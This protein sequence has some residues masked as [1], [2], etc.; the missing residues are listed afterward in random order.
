MPEKET[1]QRARRDKA[2][3]KKPTVQAGEFVREEMHHLREGKHDAASPKQAI[4]IGLA[5]AR[6]AGVDLPPPKAG[7]AKRKTRQSAQSAYA[8]GQ[9]EGPLS[10]GRKTPARKRTPA[11]KRAATPASKRGAAKKSTGQ[12]GR[13]ASSRGKTASRGT[14]AKKTTARKTTRSRS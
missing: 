9:E 8:K 14:A 5:K 4:A 2:E 7:Q 10:E 12:K 1:I 13:T 6:R 11:T 3:G